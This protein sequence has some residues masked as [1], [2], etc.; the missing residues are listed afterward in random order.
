MLELKNTSEL[1]VDVAMGALL[2]DSEDLAE[3]VRLLED[4]VDRL[5]SQVQRAA[6]EASAAGAVTADQALAIIRLAQATEHI[7]D[8]A[9]EIADV[10]LRDVDPH[11][12]LAASV[13][14]SDVVLVR[15][16]LFEDSAL[17]GKP[18]ADAELTSETGMHVIAMRRQGAW[19]LGP[20][21]DEVLE[22]GDVLL[23]RG[24]AEGRERLM[25]LRGTPPEQ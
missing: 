7:A 14:D 21:H 12:V 16:R 3:E 24:P 1:M 18:V 4:H 9:Q 20:G 19:L 25:A 17:V 10:V 22:A 23:A 13:A 8:A 5:D 2:Y 6:L 11:P 15:A